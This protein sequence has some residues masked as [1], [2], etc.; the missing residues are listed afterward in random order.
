M[1]F[2]VVVAANTQSRVDTVTLAV[3][4]G[5]TSLLFITLVS[6]N[7]QPRICVRLSRFSPVHSDALLSAVRP[8]CMNLG[9][10]ELMPQHGNTVTTAH[11][12]SGHL[13]A[14]SWLIAADAS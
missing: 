11:S 12:S 4:V 8:C 10:L 1:M 13:S 2:D 9:L 7:A 14:T 5:L 3:P 6:R